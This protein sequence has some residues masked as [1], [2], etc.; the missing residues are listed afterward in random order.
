M[1]IFK[2]P[3][4]TTAQRLNLVFEESEI[5]YDVDLKQYFGGDNFTQGGF[6]IGNNF[7]INRELIT[8]TQE[9]LNSKSFNILKSPVNPEKTKLTFINGT[10]QIYSIDFLI[11][12][13]IIT[14]ENLGLDNFIE[15]NDIILIEYN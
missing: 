5:F 10:I 7:E 12:Q 13:N 11:N 4:I 2:C 15:L 8:I 14:W 9:N 1:A 3:K 6:L